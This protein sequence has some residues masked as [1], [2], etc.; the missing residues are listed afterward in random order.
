[1]VNVSSI[2]A[3]IG[4]PYQGLYSASKAAL[5][6]STVD[7]SQASRVDSFSHF[8]VLI[9]FSSSLRR[10]VLSNDL[11]LRVSCVRPGP[12]RSTF[13]KVYNGRNGILLIAP[14]F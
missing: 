5:E 3:E 7:S 4:W 8:I 10:E 14:F 13:A 9:A 2:A 12:V 6:G 11:P 1:M